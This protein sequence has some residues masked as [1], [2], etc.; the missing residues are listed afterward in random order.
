M[1]SSLANSLKPLV[2]MCAAQGS[3]A[4]VR[5]CKRHAR[6]RTTFVKRVLVS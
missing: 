6:P 5:F 2:L 4:R 3:F 1:Q